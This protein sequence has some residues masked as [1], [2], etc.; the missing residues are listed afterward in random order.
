VYL[1]YFSVSKAIIE[2]LGNLEQYRGPTGRESLIC[3]FAR[4]STLEVRWGLEMGIS[5]TVSQ[6]YI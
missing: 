5:W 1:A 3:E 4:H 6:L 2:V